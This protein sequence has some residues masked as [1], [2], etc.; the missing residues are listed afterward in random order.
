[1]L[2]TG[3]DRSIKDNI[4]TCAWS[5]TIGNHYITH[6]GIIIIER[7]PSNS[8][9]AKRAGLCFLL[10]NLG[11]IFT[12]YKI[13]KAKI[14]IYIDNMQ[15]LE[16]SSLLVE[17]TGP[18]K[19]L[20][21][22]YNLISNIDHFQKRIKNFHQSTIKY[23]HIYSHLNNKSKR[24][25]ILCTKGKN[26]LQMHLQ[27]TTAR[28]L[29][30]ACDKEASLQHTLRNPLL[31]PLKPQIISMK[32]KGHTITTKNLNFIHSITNSQNY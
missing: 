3:I 24:G 10:Q 13:N 6:R 25:H 20:I 4:M 2:H 1:M 12:Q 15:A 17:G 5:I 30:K 19:F 22:D 23:S 14:E 32:I 29:N 27:R 8:T 31:I 18:Y 26:I 16:Y 28:N 7:R 21:D 11:H 9:R